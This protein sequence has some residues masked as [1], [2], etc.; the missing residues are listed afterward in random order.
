MVRRRAR[1]R[2]FDEACVE[3]ELFALC[4]RLRRTQSEKLLAVDV[5]S[6]GQRK[7]TPA[8][9][10]CCVLL[11][12]R[13]DADFPRLLEADNRVSALLYTLEETASLLR[14]LDKLERGGR[15]GGRLVS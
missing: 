6:R 13:T 4:A 8:A 3:G 9:T 1:Y 12:Q 11:K 14:R 5:E 15:R 10:A 7:P 2:F